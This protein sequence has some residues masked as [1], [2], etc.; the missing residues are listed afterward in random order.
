M[1][2]FANA[3]TQINRTSAAR[4]AGELRYACSGLTNTE[5]FSLTARCLGRASVDTGKSKL[6]SF[7]NAGRSMC[8]TA[9]RYHRDGMKT[10]A[11][12]DYVRAKEYVLR[13]PER[14]RNTFEVFRELT[15]SQQQDQLVD[16][17]LTWI[18]FWASA[19]GADL[20]G[21]LPDTDLMLG[22]G[23]HRNIFSHTL[24]LGFETE[25]G[26]RFAVELMQ[27]LRCRLPNPHCR[28]WDTSCEF[29]EKHKR[30]SIAAMWAGIGLHF[31]RDANLL[32]A[33]TKPLDGLPVPAPMEV[34][35]ALYAA[36]GVACEISALPQTVHP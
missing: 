34:H 18:V 23:A 28:A 15:R 14:A 3:Y 25:I 20:E 19:G 9:K 35:Q 16:F 7:K 11:S 27:E 30:A 13:L 21:G 26:L 10:A 29:L 17:M 1:T 12:D 24:L 33:G 2:V 5:W 8:Q 32:A 22:I 4:I 6:I 31:V 36:N